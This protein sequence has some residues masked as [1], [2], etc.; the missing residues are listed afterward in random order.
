TASVMTRQ[1][2]GQIHLYC[3]SASKAWQRYS[4]AQERLLQNPMFEIQHICSSAMGEWRKMYVWCLQVCVA[5]YRPGVGCV[6]VCVNI[7][8]DGALYSHFL[9]LQ[10]VEVGF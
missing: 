3:R 4:Y 6:C 7:L 10:C 2:G 5:E 9:S 8:S 1:H